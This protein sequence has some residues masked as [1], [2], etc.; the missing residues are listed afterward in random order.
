MTGS[1]SAPAGRVLVLAGGLSHE[2]DVSM[3]S[4]RRITEALRHHGLEV[5]QRDVDAALLPTLQADPPSCVVP[6]V[7]G[8]SGEDGALREVLELFRLPYVGATPQAC[9]FAFDKPVASALVAQAGLAVPASVVLPAQTF[10]EVGAP[11]VMAAL[12]DRLGLPLLQRQVNDEHAAVTDLAVERD[13]AAHEPAELATDR[14]P[15]PR[16]PIP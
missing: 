13:V 2:R 9:R 11:A 5:D 15:Q 10:R 1:S 8:E 16:A 3:R 4:G 7:H 6:V 12:L 14:Q